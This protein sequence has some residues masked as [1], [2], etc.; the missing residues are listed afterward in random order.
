MWCL[1]DERAMCDEETLRSRNFQARRP[2]KLSPMSMERF[3]FKFG[4]LFLGDRWTRMRKTYAPCSRECGR[5]CLRNLI[6]AA[7]PG[8]RCHLQECTLGNKQTVQRLYEAGTK[9]SC[10]CMLKKETPS[11]LTSKANGLSHKL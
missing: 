7:A 1:Q 10:A 8:R 5:V 6:W 3:G 4:G 11:V 9:E 2:P